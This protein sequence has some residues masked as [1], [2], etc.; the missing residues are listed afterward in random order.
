MT[1]VLLPTIIQ[2]SRQPYP[3]GI[4]NPIEKQRNL[5]VI[6]QVICSLGLDLGLFDP[7]T[8]SCIS[9]SA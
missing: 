8:Y 7:K 1:C 2:L 3:E 4:I 6:S 5:P 9:N